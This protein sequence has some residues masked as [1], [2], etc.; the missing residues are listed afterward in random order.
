MRRLVCLI[1]R[2]V[3]MVCLMFSR[4]R[5]VPVMKARG[6]SSLIR[7]WCKTLESIIQPEQREL[8]LCKGPLKSSAVYLHT[9]NNKCSCCLHGVYLLTAHNY[10]IHFRRSKVFIALLLIERQISTKPVHYIYIFYTYQNIKYG[11]ICFVF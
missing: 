9:W 2:I 3:P 8:H 10:I 5:D 1:G 7:H 11:V 6:Q 4:S